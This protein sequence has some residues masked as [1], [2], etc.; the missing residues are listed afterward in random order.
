[1]AVELRACDSCST[2]FVCCA[3]C[4]DAHWA[5]AHAHEEPLYDEADADADADDGGS[6]AHHA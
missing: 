3:A 2:A 5:A 4:E 1:V 6:A